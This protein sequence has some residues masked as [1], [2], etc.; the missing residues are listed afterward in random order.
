MYSVSLVPLLRAR[1][2]YGCSDSAR[3]TNRKGEVTGKDYLQVYPH[4]NMPH[5]AQST[6]SL[7]P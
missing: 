6:P 4:M 3:A 5:L 1:V 7:P 2:A